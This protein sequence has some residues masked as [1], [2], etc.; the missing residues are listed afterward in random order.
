MLVYISIIVSAL[1]VFISI[2]I[3]VFDRIK[4]NR[5]LR[6]EL[7][8]TLEKLVNVA[9]ERIKTI[10][11]YKSNASILEYEKLEHIDKNYTAQRIYLINHAVYLINKIPNS[12][13]AN[14][15]RIIAYALMII[16]DPKTSIFY[17]SKA[18]KI[19]KNEYDRI[20]ILRG[21]AANLLR[22]NQIAEGRS[23]YEIILQTHENDKTYENSTYITLTHWAAAELIYTDGAY[24]PQIII[25][26]EK[27]IQNSNNY[28]ENV[29]RNK[30]LETIKSK[31]K[32]KVDK[33]INKL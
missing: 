26:I 7:T 10:Y 14:D 13:N 21:Y 9:M 20:L 3:F 12:T 5:Y 27:L 8:Q 33:K 22:N 15:Y 6:T 4:H 28:Q 25:R 19:C 16:G 31:F 24:L 1:A 17:Y 23:K 29:G 32:E 11:D 2:V 18:L 30:K